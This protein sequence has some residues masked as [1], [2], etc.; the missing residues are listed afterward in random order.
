M[1]VNSLEQKVKWKIN[2][3]LY[4]ETRIPDRFKNLPL[5]L[6]VAIYHEDDMIVLNKWILLFFPYFL[7][8]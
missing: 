1:T 2:N 5:H 6:F 7:I 8:H 4:A 3:K